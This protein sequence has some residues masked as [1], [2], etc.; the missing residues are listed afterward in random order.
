VS[1]P[2]RYYGGNH[3]HYLT[4]STYRRARFRLRALQTSVHRRAG[5]PAD[6]ARLSH[7][8]VRFDA[9]TFSFALVAHREREPLANHAEAGRAD[10]AVYL[11]K[12]AR[13]PGERLVRQD[14]GP[15]QIAL[16]RARRS[17]LS[18]VAAQVL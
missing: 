5:G 2:H 7:R 6:G 4:T 17:A 18:G 1:Q 10:G 8:W 13:A 9:G 16:D 3:L 12:L 15:I 11:K 14:A